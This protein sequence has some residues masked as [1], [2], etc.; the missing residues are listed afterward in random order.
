MKRM[1][2]FLL[3]AVIT[4][5]CADDS[6]A[7]TTC[8]EGTVIGKIRSWGGGVAVSMETSALS[9]HEWNGFPHVIEA[10][11]IPGNFWEPGQKLY[12]TARSG[13]DEETGY[14]SADGDESAKPIIFVTNFA[15]RECPE[16]SERR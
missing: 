15:T 7:P 9:T 6:M 10:L 8:Y 2:P 4:A 12:F 3:S 11:N 13:T 16:Q 5:S 14:R 1:I